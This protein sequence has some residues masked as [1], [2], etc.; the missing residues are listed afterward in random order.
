MGRIGGPLLADNLLRNG[1]N[2]AFDTN[3]LFFNVN[4]KTIGINTP[5]PSAD[6]HV[7]NLNNAGNAT[8]GSLQT[9][10]ANITNQLEINNFIISG[11]T[12][13][14]VT[15]EI[16]IQPNQSSNPTINMAGFATNNLYIYG[17][18]ITNTVTNDSINITG[19]TSAVGAITGVISVS[20]MSLIY[21]QTLPV[22]QTGGTGATIYFPVGSTGESAVIVTPGVGYTTGTATIT[23]YATT[24]YVNI[25]SVATQGGIN[26][27]NDVGNVELTI[28]GNLWAD[29]NITT[30]GN[31]TA[32]GNITLGNSPT[33]TIAFDGEIDSNIIP[34][35]TNTYNL[36]SNSLV[37]ANVYSNNTTINYYTVPTINATNIIGGNVEFNSNTIFDT[38]NSNTILLSTSG[39][40]LVNF[41]G[42]NYIEGNDIFQPSSGSLIISSTG[43]G[44]VA[45]AGT[46]GVVIPSGASSN[47]PLAPLTGTLRYN[48]SIN[49]LEVYSGTAWIPAY[50]NNATLS[51]SDVQDLVLAYEL[52]LGY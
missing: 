11:N 12:I 10:N 25:T 42:I 34:N 2:L 26:I 32:D 31:I 15:D 46:Y 33:D 39:T 8:S 19:D 48:V 49:T 45:F 37:W 35:A 24:F 4:S 40:G 29:G 17:N 27:S 6:L 38:N 3:L 20:D 51:S 7:G 18:N 44:H 13:S 47:Y 21:G 5:G 52:I 9:I 22:V 28:S 36:G 41:N 23:Q 50:G 30:A 1:N 43:S 14:H 16:I